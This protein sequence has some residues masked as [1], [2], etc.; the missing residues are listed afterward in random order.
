MKFE[1]VVK[2]RSP[3][4]LDA[5][6]RPQYLLCPRWTREC[7]QIVCLA[8][9]GLSDLPQTR[10]SNDLTVGPGLTHRTVASQA[11]QVNIV[12]EG[13][14]VRGVPVH[15][16]AVEGE[17]DGVQHPVYRIHHS[18]AILASRAV[19]DGQT[20]RDEVILDINNDYRTAG[21]YDLKQQNI[22]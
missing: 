7:H 10:G 18:L 15:A 9:P 1:V 21:L 12:N 17:G 5:V 13:D 6:T 2:L 22:N 4:V 3:G 14:V 8:G 16:V 20:A 11:P 19:G